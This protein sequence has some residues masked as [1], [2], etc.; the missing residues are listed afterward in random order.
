MLLKFKGD[1]K[2][3]E[4]LKKVETAAKRCKD[5]T[6]NLLRFSEQEA[7][8]E[9]VEIN[10]HEVLQDAYS[11]TEQRIQAQE[12]ETIWE[13]EPDLP[14]V[15]GDHRQLM[16]VF[17]NL[18]SNARTAME[19]GGQLTVHSRWSQEGGV[20][21]EV[22]DTGR[23]ISPEHLARVFEPFFT[24]KDVWTNTGLG[25]SVAYRIISDHGGRISAQSEEGQGSA[26]TVALPAGG[27]RA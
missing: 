11:M 17:F 13:L 8:P 12:I 16:Q 19:T 20:E 23:G 22:K 24:T 3:Q 1:E 10:L 4:I 21:V 14:H 18:F 25:L 9:H 26:F 5:V 6:Q 7:D 2:Q 27:E 15:M